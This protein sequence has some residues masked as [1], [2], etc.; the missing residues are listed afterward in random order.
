[1]KKSLLLGLA[2][3]IA[4]L[5]SCANQDTAP[6]ADNS[7]DIQRLQQELTQT[8]SALDAARASANVQVPASS[9]GGNTLLPPDAKA[10]ECYARAWVEPRYRTLTNEVIAK[11]ASERVEVIPAVYDWGTEQV[12]VKEASQRVEKIPAVYGTE[13]EKIM[14]KDAERVWRVA[15]ARNSNPASAE[16][17][18]AAAKAGAPLDSAAVGTCFHEHVKP[19]RYETQTAQVL[20]SP[21]DYSI[22]TVPAKYR[23][24]EKQVLVKEASTRLVSTPARYETQ[25]DRVVDVPAHTIWKKGT[26]PIQRI[27]EATG[28][29]M[30][31]VEVPATYKTVSR[32]V[33]SSPASTQ[34]IAIPAE[35]KTVK[36]RELATPASERKVAI[37]ARYQDVTSTKKV[38]DAQFV[39]HEI[40][41]K[42][43][44]STSRTGSQVC[45][46][47]TPAQYRTVTRT[48]ITSPAATRTIE[49][50]AEYSTVKVRKLV[51]AA[52]EKRIAI[53]EERKTVT[54]RELEKDGYMEW[55]SILCDTNATTDLIRRLQSTLKT[56]GYNPGAIDG[57]VGGDTIRAV[58]AYQAKNSLP[59]DKYLNIK[60][61]RHMG[62]L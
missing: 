30:C 41:D 47:E 3:S 1:M 62:V 18:A 12:L 46:T 21:D 15:L 37:P 25:T 44:S 33:Q 26:G 60:T 61:L 59:V 10:G 24:V 52:Q 49:I 34:T 2:A 56:K 51:S 20:A 54:S 43:M 8:R 27:D 48:V 53:P 4:L 5:S 6:V 31:L 38:S 14:V 36:V 19:A 7:A 35:Y 55:R 11:E 40:H 39:W 13:S 16:L 58:N 32:R 9:L 22:V 45:L 42:T 23:W 28:E 50:P 17:L 57:V 29:I